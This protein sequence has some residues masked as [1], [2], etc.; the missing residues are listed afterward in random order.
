MSHNSFPP[1][2]NGVEVPFPRERSV[3]DFFRSMVQ[4][5]PDAMAV[6]EGDRLMTYRELDAHSNRVA[7]DLLQRGVK[8]EEAV[9]ILLPASCDFLA[10]VVGI[11][12]AG[13]TYFPIDV[14][15]PVKRIE[16]LLGDTG[17]RYVLSD[18]AGMERL[19]AW[20]GKVLDLKQ[21]LASGVEAKDPHV[22]ADPH[23]RAYITYTSG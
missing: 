15:V 9:V 21:I 14:D 22:A 19:K 11:L 10:A 23:R 2:W 1:E 16:F 4:A 12:K 6:K 20:P 5:Q 17:C 8:L 18:V 7:N 13:G 3:L